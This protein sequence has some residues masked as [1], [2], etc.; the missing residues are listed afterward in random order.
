VDIRTVGTHNVGASNVMH[1]VSKWLAIPVMLFDIG[2]GAFVVWSARELGFSVGMQAAVG[3]CAILGHNWPV[4]LGFSGGRGIATSLGVI[5]TLSLP[6]GLIMVVAAYSFAAFKQMGLGVF[7]VLV[8][9][10]FLSW[11]GAGAFGIEE[12]G[13]VTL[14]YLAI[15]VIAY[16]RR[17]IHRRSEL[18]RCTPLGE[19][20][21]NRLFFDRDIRDRK[22]WL[23]REQA[24][25]A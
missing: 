25:H 22:L 18:S 3:I 9:L 2:K 1:V 13:P 17:L 8:I 16:L 20:I 7:I 4:F 15:T 19:L 14:G 11:F 23:H 12:R 21:F 5:I 6:I 10:P 24:E